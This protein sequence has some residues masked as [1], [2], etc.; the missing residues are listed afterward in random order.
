MKGGRKNL[1]TKHFVNKL[2]WKMV[3]IIILTGK[4]KGSVNGGK[5]EV[6]EKFLSAPPLFHF[7]KD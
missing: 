4:R 1:F 5:N 7:L 2:Q 6:Q 3:I